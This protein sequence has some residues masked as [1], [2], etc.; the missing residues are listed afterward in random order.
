MTSTTA[1]SIS[2]QCLTVA[3]PVVNDFWDVDRV[4]LGLGF[5]LGLV[6]G[7]IISILIVIACLKDNANRRVSFKVIN[8]LNYVMIFAK[9]AIIC[10]TW[11]CMPCFKCVEIKD[12]KIF[13]KLMPKCN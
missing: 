8:V 9:I 1:A 13:Y 6:F 10:F 5:L 11:A 2:G 4:W 3:V 7:A 12:F